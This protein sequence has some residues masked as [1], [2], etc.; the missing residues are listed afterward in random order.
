MKRNSMTAA[1]IL[2]VLAV[3]MTV[4]SGCT[5]NLEQYAEKAADIN[6]LV[7]DWKGYTAVYVKEDTK[8][9]MEYAEISKKQSAPTVSNTGEGEVAGRTC[10]GYEIK[11][12]AGDLIKTYT[13]QVDKETGICLG[14]QTSSKINTINTGEDISF[15]CVDF[16][17]E[18][19]ILPAY[20]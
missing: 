18:N 4:M 14:W 19:I 15:T 8:P 16:Q 1:F 3:M 2:M 6:Q 20:S 10:D 7:S 12:G 13:V 11:T 9:F 5:E 17:T